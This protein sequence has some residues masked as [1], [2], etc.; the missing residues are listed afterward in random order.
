MLNSLVSPGLNRDT[1]CTWIICEKSRWCAQHASALGWQWQASMTPGSIRLFEARL[2]PGTAV[3]CGRCFVD[4]SIDRRLT[5]RPN[6]EF[7]STLYDTNRMNWRV[8][9]CV[10]CK[11]I[12]RASLYTTRTYL[13]QPTLMIQ[14]HDEFGHA[15]NTCIYSHKWCCPFVECR[16]I[17]AFLRLLGWCSSHAVVSY[18]W[19][20]RSN[21]IRN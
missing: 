8:Q 6:R 14:S 20:E 11:V 19:L 18:L 13:F 17:D 10:C 2:S 5:D 16:C 1:D 21:F 3:T 9:R 4:N 7:E 12:I 15:C